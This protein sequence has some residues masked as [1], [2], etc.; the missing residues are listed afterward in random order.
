MISSN[1]YKY[2]FKGQND[3]QN[4][5]NFY[6]FYPS[7]FGIVQFSRVGFNNDLTQA[8]LNYTRFDRNENGELRFYYLTK[9]NEKWRIQ[10]YGEIR[11]N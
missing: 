2:L 6:N 7:S 3:N 9:T 4:W 5:E 1:E 11:T 8:I 10:F